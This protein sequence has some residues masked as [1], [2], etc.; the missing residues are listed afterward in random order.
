MNSFVDKNVG[1]QQNLTFD[2]N[3]MKE[4]L[5]NLQL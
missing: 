2:V 5:F 1:E 4:E 3:K